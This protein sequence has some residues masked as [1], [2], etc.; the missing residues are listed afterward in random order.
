M[1]H[2]RSI[3]KMLTVSEG[4]WGFVHQK[5]FYRW[6]YASLTFFAIFAVVVAF[7][8]IGKGTTYSASYVDGEYTQ[9]ELN[10]NERLLQWIYV[11]Y[12][13]PLGFAWLVVYFGKF[14]CC[15][16]IKRLRK[17]RNY[18]YNLLLA[19]LVVAVFYGLVIKMVLRMDLNSG[20]KLRSAIITAVCE[21]GLVC[22]EV[23]DE[24]KTRKER[25]RRKRLLREQ[26][27]AEEQ[28]F[29]QKESEAG[30]LQPVAAGGML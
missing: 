26:Q 11:F 5:R 20:P 25:H 22:I 12:P 28:V 29:R 4:Y 27:Q 24:R 15:I 9:G 6:S 10:E 14:F 13:T 19:S 16:K 18:K 7:F 3:G 21:L 8:D 30:E 2:R 23:F 1:G 17:A